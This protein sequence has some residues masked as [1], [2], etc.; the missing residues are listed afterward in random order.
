MMLKKWIVLLFSSLFMLSAC[1]YPL[2]NQTLNNAADVKL[3]IE[4]ARH[5]SD[6]SGR[7]QPALLV[8]RGP[9]VDTTP[10]SLAK[11]PTW[12]KSYIV[13]RGDR[14]PF[15]YYSRLIA[16]GAGNNI[17]T[18]FQTGLD[19]NKPITM[20][21]AGPIGGALDL[22][23]SKAGFVYGVSDNTI[24]WKEFVTRTFDIAFLPGTSDYLMGRR[25]GG[26]GSTAQQSSG[27]TVQ[28]FVSSDASEDEYSNLSAKLS[29]WADVENTIKQLLSPQGKVTVSQTSTTVTVYDRPANVN[30]I[31]Q[32]IANLNKDLSKQVLIK[33][34]VLEVNLE[35]SFNFGLNWDVI[36][37]AFVNSAF[38]IKGNYGTP[39]TITSLTTQNENAF[40]GAP[41]F[42]F[43]QTLN[44]D[45]NG[46]LPSYTI[47]LNALSQQGHTSVVT[48]PRVVCM[49]NQVCAVRIVN[50]TGYVAKLQ[51]TTLAG[52]ETGN[53]NTV[54]TEITPGNLITGFTLYVLP[55]ILKDKIY[56]QINADL[57]TNNGFKETGVLGNGSQIRM[58]LPLI[59]EKHFN[60]RSIIRSGDILILAGMRQMTNIANANQFIKSQALGGKGAQQRNIET[61]VLITPFILDG[62]C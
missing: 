32:Y 30:L 10:I 62:A 43:N 37:K 42:G 50:Q 59:S 31:A 57:S 45:G 58:E 5:Q 3:R 11:T 60:Q 4:A 47:L 8:K 49:N 19:P 29:V 9:Y 56:L 21:Y 25:S 6:R 20:N 2:Y 35:N 18:K 22:L 39:V 46:L 15:S 24:T 40:N 54:T 28:N 36:A 53:N 16:S 55:K 38:T 44:P 48:E 26:G 51:N 13:I 1:H 23:A 27:G 52:G 12:L 17:L 7:P 14:L 34:Q 61:I 41:S 33:V